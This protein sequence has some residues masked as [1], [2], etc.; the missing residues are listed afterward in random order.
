MR[1]SRMTGVKVD[2][3]KALWLDPTVST[4]SIRREMDLTTDMLQRH[5]KRLGIGYRPKCDNQYASWRT[6]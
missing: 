5:A 2:R 4:A 3:F 1:P 6:Q